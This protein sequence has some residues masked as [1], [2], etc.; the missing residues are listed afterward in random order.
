MKV[1][2]ATVHTG[3]RVHPAPPHQRRRWLWVCILLGLLGGVVGVLGVVSYRFLRDE[4]PSSTLQARYLASLSSQ[5]S[6]TVEPEPSPMI[7]YPKTGPYDLR[8]GYVG[9]P[10]FIQRLHTLGFAITAQARISPKLAQVVDS[11]LFTIYHEKTQ[12][13]LRLFDQAGQMVFSA[14]SHPRLPHFDD[15]PPLVWHTLLFIENRELFDARYP[16]RNPAVE[17]DRF[18]LAIFHTLLRV[19]PFDIH[20]P[21]G[22]TLATQLEKFRH[23]PDGRTTSVWRSCARWG[24]RHCAPILMGP[25]PASTAG[26]RPGVSELRPAR[27]RTRLRRSPQPR[28]R[29]VGVVRHGLCDGES[30]L[31]GRH[32]RRHRPRE[33]GTGDSIS[34]GPL[35]THRAAASRLVPRGGLRG[36]A[37]PG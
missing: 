8:L 37:D 9:L 3:D 14:L 1:A 7:R 20:R 35:L 22:S 25:I 30:L 19:L 23:S 6:F 4:F 21:G 16:Q 27:S 18:G 29:P 2:S 36:V 5:L 28:R 15:I 10:G 33:S 26:D 24:A 31:A 13:G 34:A 12:A 32:A 17:W 11:G